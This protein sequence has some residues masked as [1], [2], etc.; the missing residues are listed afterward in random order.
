MLRRQQDGERKERVKR[1]WKKQ[2]H[3]YLF[4]G[5]DSQSSYKVFQGF[6]LNLKVAI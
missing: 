4:Q 1:K 5:E 3:F 6:R 2:K